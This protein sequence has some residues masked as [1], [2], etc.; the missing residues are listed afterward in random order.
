MTEELQ[1]FCE[2]MD[3]QLTIMEETLLDMMD[4][5]IDEVD[6]E[7]INKLFRAMHTMK[8]NAG[9]FG[10]DDVVSFAHVAENLLD[11]V[12]ND[13]IALTSDMVDLFL[14][15]NDH[16]KTLIDI[17]VNNG[18]LDEDSLEQHNNLLAQLS[19]F[20]GVKPK[21]VKSNDKETIETE[22]E[23]SIPTYDISIA[24]KDSFFSADMD[25]VSII[26]FLNVIGDISDMQI[27]DS[28]LPIIE[29]IEPLKAYITIKFRFESEE[30][31]ED[32]EGA[33]D[34][35]KDDIEL[36]IDDLNKKAQETTKEIKTE[37]KEAKPKAKNSKSNQQ[38]TQKTSSLRVDSSK[39]DQLINLISEMVIANAKVTQIANIDD[40]TELIE[41]TDTLTV[42]LEEIR[43]SV[44]DIRMVQVGSSFN[45]LRRIV[46]DT[47]KKLGK[48]IEF[49]ISG[50]ETELDKTVIEKISDPLVHMLRNSVDHGVEAVEKR[51][52]K[53]KKEK[54]RID[55]RAYP[56]AGSIV[57]EI[58]D[59]G[60]GIPKDIILAKAIENKIVSE[61]E[62][63]TDKQIYNLIFAAGLSTAEA[64]S[65]VSGRGVGMDVVKR[66][67]EDLK[68]TVDVDSTL[69]QGSK[70]T[71][72]LPLTLAIIDGFLVQ[73]GDTKY[74]IPLEM[75]QECIEL[76]AEHK[77]KMKDN[78]FI[79]L[80]GSILPLLDSS[81]YFETQNLKS[82]R[83]NII[84]INSGIQRAGL[85][86]NELHGEFQTVIKPLG[87]VFEKVP[88]VSGGT[89]L[90]S[91]E[92]ALIL[93]VPMLLGSIGTAYNKLNK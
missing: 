2:D 38:K 13:K 28:N 41:A 73:A 51:I 46:S 89:I 61:N 21:S 44:M 1:L 74:I 69:G 3:E 45:K 91:G 29:D 40:N 23:F 14:V 8:G 15:V 72:R 60:A 85:I 25:L 55:L 6:S 47:A 50:E 84:I 34:F 88:W 4:I 26:K 32:I 79:N 52:A 92:V 31:F 35:I 22:K 27:D 49:V 76:T 68:G 19:E 62:K 77:E 42:M 75:I 33:F 63:L 56:D 24:P 66:N 78:E 87:D 54:G 80:R 70:I 53:G 5:S 65:D 37:K 93:D 11:E 67:I 90:G 36:V 64:V 7:M 12:R 9:M 83:E 16:S 48:D 10:F 18:T 20:L 86:V 59:D 39:V 43:S 71:V 82:E 30:P 81:E 17:T 57:I 58:E